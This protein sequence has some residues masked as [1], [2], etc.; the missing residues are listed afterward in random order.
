M[1]VALQRFIY[2]VSIVKNLISVQVVHLQ[3]LLKRLTF[4]VKTL[5]F[6]KQTNVD[7]NRLATF[8]SSMTKKIVVTF[9]KPTRVWLTLIHFC[10]CHLT[11][12][13]N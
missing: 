13:T 8:H 12:V 7:K 2:N 3:V 1:S 6:L 9:E 4:I 10:H 11:V 5:H